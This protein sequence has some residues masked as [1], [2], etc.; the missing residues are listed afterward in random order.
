MG[1]LAAVV[2]FILPSFLMLL[3][4]GIVYPQLR[5]L[6][7]VDGIFRGLSPAVAAL[8]L[9]TAVRLGSRVAYTPDGQPGGWRALWRDRWSL[10][11]M[12]AAGIAVAVIG[13]GVVE[14]ILLAGLLGLLRGATRMVPGTAEAFEARWR[15]LRRRVWDAARAGGTALSNPW[16]RRWRERDEDDLGGAVPLWVVAALLAP[17][18]LA[19]LVEIGTLMGV[20][21]RA[22]AITFGGGFVM[23]P[24]LEAEL[25]RTH[26]W[27]SPRAFADA[28]ALGQI[29]PG[30]VVITAT[31]VGYT[32]AGLAG[33]ILATAAVFA[34]AFLMVLVVGSSVERF[35]KSATLQAF[36]QGVQPAV[37]GLMFAAAVS[38]ARTGIHDGL[39]VGIGVLA[40]VLLR[41][42]RISPVHVL[43]GAA[44]IG[45]IARS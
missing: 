21:L 25:V 44:V 2:G 40:F 1:A 11:L 45:L 28:M 24:L 15:W 34:P 31:F 7:Y 32:V 4:F 35:R 38:L 26:F 14:V 36:L 16:W 37:V 43:L 13:I 39:G 23:I 30:P 42:A 9:T 5:H 12:L 18:A 17:P 6:G 29:T 33:A 22:G 41:F 8:V 19:Q 20:F 3:A 10:V 27:L